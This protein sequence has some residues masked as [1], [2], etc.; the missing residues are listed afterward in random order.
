LLKYYCDIFK[1]ALRAMGRLCQCVGY[2][3][4]PYKDY[5]DLLEILLQLLKTELSSS[6]RRLTMR[7]LGIIGFD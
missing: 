1:A 7:V 3:V 4:E 2:V 6:M 5:P